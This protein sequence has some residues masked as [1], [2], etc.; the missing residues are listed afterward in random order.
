[1]AALWVRAGGC[2]ARP[3][4]APRDG[5]GCPTDTTGRRPAQRRV[6]RPGRRGVP[7]GPVPADHLHAGMETEPVG[8][9]GSFS[10]HEH[11][12][13][14]V[15]VG[16]IDSTVPYWWP[17]RNANSS[18]PRTVPWPTGGSS[19]GTPLDPVVST[20]VIRRSIRSQLYCPANSTVHST[21]HRARTCRAIARSQRL[22]RL[23]TGQVV[24]TLRNMGEHLAAIDAWLQPIFHHSEARNS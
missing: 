7:T 17:R 14:S 19:I 8:E 5:T 6:R 2:G 20:Y 15:S 16:Q 21:G 13:R 9:I 4:S 24:K 3:P 1:M 18:T 12:D 10:A 23:T 22:T 11:V